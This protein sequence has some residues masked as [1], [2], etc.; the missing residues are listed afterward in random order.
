MPRTAPYNKELSGPKCHEFETLIYSSVF[1]T[2][3]SKTT[4]REWQNLQWRAH[5]LTS[6]LGLCLPSSPPTQD[7]P[8]LA[9]NECIRKNSSV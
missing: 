3:L 4:A 7:I 5:L 6:Q 9:H 2:V 1:Q 8:Y